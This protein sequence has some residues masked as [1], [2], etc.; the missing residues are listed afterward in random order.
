[1]APS[2]NIAT[3]AFGGQT[4]KINFIFYRVISILASVPA[5][6]NKPSISEKITGPV[7]VKD[8][9]LKEISP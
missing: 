7:L 4:T 3:S 9:L 6:R 2:Q 8:F 5:L 1:M